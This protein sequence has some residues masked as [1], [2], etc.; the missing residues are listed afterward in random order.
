[1]ENDES[2]EK[3]E[4]YISYL[5]IKKRFDTLK[6]TRKAKDI[7]KR[8]K[9]R[10]T[11]VA[12]KR[13]SS[14]HNWL[15]DVL[16]C[17]EK[18][19]STFTLHDMYNHENDLKKLHPFN[20]NI[21]AKIRQ[22]LQCLRDLDIIR[23]EKPGVYSFT[24]IKKEQTKIEEKNEEKKNDNEIMEEQRESEQKKNL[25]GISEE[26]KASLERIKINVIRN[27]EI[28]RTIDEKNREKQYDK[29]KEKSVIACQDPKCIVACKKNALVF[30][31]TGFLFVDRNRCEGE[32]PNNICI[33]LECLDA[34]SHNLLRLSE[35]TLNPKIPRICREIFSKEKIT[36]SDKK[37]SAERLRNNLFRNIEIQTKID[38]KNRTNIGEITE[39]GKNEE[40]EYVKDTSPK[41]T[42]SEL[43]NNPNENELYDLWKHKN[44]SIE[45][46]SHKYNVSPG[47]FKNLF[48]QIYYDKCMKENKDNMLKSLSP[49]SPSIKKYNVSYNSKFRILCKDPQCAN[50]C[51]HEAFTSIPEGGITR[52]DSKCDECKT[53]NCIFSCKQDELYLG[54][55]IYSKGYMMIVKKGETGLL[56]SDF[57]KNLSL[58]SRDGS[59]LSMRLE[60]NGLIKRKKILAKGRWTYYLFIQK[61][62]FGEK[63]RKE[64]TR[65]EL[66]NQSIEQVKELSKIYLYD[67][68]ADLKIEY[69]SPI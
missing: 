32:G 3:E 44:I 42:E 5:R 9:L 6:K 60:N 56:Q 67:N 52:L 38:E 33:S 12:L 59:R 58:T 62:K 51:P 49:L 20:N 46:L 18:E 57:W 41:L 53:F 22:Q 68:N 15:T 13:E 27:K 66:T 45:T 17:A 37:E 36:T 35:M 7:A 29:I 47:A 19:M 39:L 25:K 14:K 54:N 24:K 61:I 34:C 43:P 63:C 31:P 8:N 50:V 69:I 65:I 10:K 23:F 30:G 2:P 40:D 55:S 4:I 48:G 26:K 64:Q 11:I 16:K 1:M 21:K 28:Q